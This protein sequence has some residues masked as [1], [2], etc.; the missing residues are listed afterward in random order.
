MRFCDVGSAR[1]TTGTSGMGLRDAPMCL[2]YKTISIT[3]Q[4]KA[5]SLKVEDE[6]VHCNPH[7]PE[8]ADPEDTADHIAAQVVKD[9][10]FPDGLSI[11]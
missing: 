10:D 3:E 8:I 2:N 6:H 5:A 7:S 1:Y 4:Y 11:W 9:E